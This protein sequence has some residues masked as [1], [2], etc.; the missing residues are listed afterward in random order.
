[1]N[2]DGSCTVKCE[3]SPEE[4]RKAD[5]KELPRKQMMTLLTAAVCILTA[6]FIALV[7][8]GKD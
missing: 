2:E 4:N 8:L 6:T 3:F 7:L 5:E 1:L